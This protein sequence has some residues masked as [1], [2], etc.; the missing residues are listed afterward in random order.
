MIRG[1]VR[2]T[3]ENMVS[4]CLSDRLFHTV[5]SHSDLSCQ[6]MNSRRRSRRRRLLVI[7]IRAGESS[8]VGTAQ[9][10]EEVQDSGGWN[11]LEQAV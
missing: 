10:G 9:V 1:L 7:Y 8:Q 11:Q 5:P 2:L 6:Y 4:V 3:C